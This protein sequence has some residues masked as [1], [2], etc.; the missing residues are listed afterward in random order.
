MILEGFRVERQLRAG[1]T[2]FSRSLER[3]QAA[4]SR[5]SLFRGDFLSSE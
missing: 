2:T 5:G 4:D 1:D 3:K